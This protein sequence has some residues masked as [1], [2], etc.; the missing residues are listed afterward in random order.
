MILEYKR[1][2]QFIRREHTGEKCYTITLNIEYKNGPK[3]NKKRMR[4]HSV[5]PL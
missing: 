4:R 3:H 5:S 1:I 2:I